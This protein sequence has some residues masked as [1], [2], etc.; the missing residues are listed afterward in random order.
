MLIVI[1]TPD[2]P[3]LLFLKSESFILGDRDTGFLVIMSSEVV[4]VKESNNSAISC[5]R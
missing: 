3:T 1:S 2:P 4:Q 5:I